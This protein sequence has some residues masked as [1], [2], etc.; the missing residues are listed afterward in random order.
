VNKISIIIPNYNHGQLIKDSVLSTYQQSIPPDEILVIDDGSTDDSLEILEKLESEV[1]ILRVISCTHNQGTLRAGMIGVRESKHELLI[2]RAADDIL[3]INA[4]KHAKD[5][6]LRYPES[7][8]AFGDLIFFH[9]NPLLGTLESLSLSKE[10]AFFSS[11]KL[12]EFLKS[13]L[14][15][16]EP[17]CVVSKSALLEAG[18]LFEEA[19]WYSGWLCFVSIALKY[20]FTYIPHA[21]NT[22][23][24]NPQSYGTA[25]LRDLESQNS[26]FRFMV[27]H[28]MNY[29][30]SDRQKFI[31]SGAFS[32]F[33]HQFVNFLSKEKESL[34]SNS[35]ALTSNFNKIVNKQVTLPEHGITGVIKRRMYE[36]RHELSFISK[37]T[38]PKVFI[39]GAG[40]HTKKML[41]VFN[42]LKFP[43]IS[44]IILSN[45]EKTPSVFGIP[46]FHLD[47]LTN[48]NVDLI[49]LSSKAF[50]L[51]MYEKIRTKYSKMNILTFWAKQLTKLPEIKSPNCSILNS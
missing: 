3:P 46:L 26:I 50:E 29:P 40:T 8:I 17:S 34:P 37:K 39:F 20:G 32:I 23:R 19:K 6:F 15:L 47:M 51:E 43:K 36:L 22:F 16:L 2:L 9:E 11:E 44:G 25:N 18:G 10:T 21:L 33:S 42:F 27:N 14:N 28:V 38:S 31:N 48:L 5:A 4:I 7:K 49:I 12:I 30:D 45:V 41:E 35:E 1:P 13:D 24:L